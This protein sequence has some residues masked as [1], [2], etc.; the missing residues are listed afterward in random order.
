MR[1][2]ALAL[3]GVVILVIALTAVMLFMRPRPVEHGYTSSITSTRVK[4]SGSTAMPIK[5]VIIIIILENHAF[6]NI[7]GLYPFGTPPIINS[8]TLSLMRPVGLNLSVVINGVRP[9]YANSVILKDP[10]EGYVNYHT[11]WDLGPWMA[12]LGVR[13]HSP[14]HIYPTSRF[15]YSGTTLRSMCWLITSSPQT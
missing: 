3:V 4:V 13:A 10:W 6:D 7:Y 2:R 8:I 1:G 12:S 15:P 11:D 5:H 14:W 9:Y